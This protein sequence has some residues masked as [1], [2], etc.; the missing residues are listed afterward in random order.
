MKIHTANAL[1]L[2]CRPRAN[3]CSALMRFEYD[4]TKHG[5]LSS[6]TFFVISPKCYK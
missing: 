2:N 5:T 6:S 4:K 3:A 1:S